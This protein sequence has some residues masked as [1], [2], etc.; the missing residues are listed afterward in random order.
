MHEDQFTATGPAFDGA[1]FPRAAF[2][3]NSVGTDSTY[4]VNVQG[5]SCGVY[6]ESGIKDSNREATQRTENVGVCG[7]GLTYGVFGRGFQTA[8]VYGEIEKAALEW[9]VK[10]RAVALS[11]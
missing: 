2:S 1:G 4:G 9:P 10:Q 6:G 7:V 5:E 3:T 11:A 8:G